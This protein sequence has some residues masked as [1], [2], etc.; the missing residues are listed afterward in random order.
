RLAEGMTI[1]AEVSSDPS[2]ARFLRSFAR[3]FALAGGPPFARVYASPDGRGFAAHADKFH[4]F[5]LQLEGEKEWKISRSPAIAAPLDGIHLDVQ[6]SPVLR[7][8]ERLRADDG[9]PV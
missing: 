7:S 4:V 8:G 6:G 5:V 1:C 2:V 3:A 9:S